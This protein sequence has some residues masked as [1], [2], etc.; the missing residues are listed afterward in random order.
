[1]KLIISLE[2][3][4]CDQCKKERKRERE[5]LREREKVAKMGESNIEKYREDK[6]TY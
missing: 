3:Q 4:V 5:R 1:V 6:K 2:Y